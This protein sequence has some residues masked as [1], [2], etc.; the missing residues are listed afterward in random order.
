M[1]ELVQTILNHHA[2]LLQHSRLP[3]EQLQSITT[4]MESFFLDAEFLL[5]LVENSKFRSLIN[6]LNLYVP[7]ISRRK[8]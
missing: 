7:P 3:V 4:L 2:I 5:N 1:S 6:A 8:L